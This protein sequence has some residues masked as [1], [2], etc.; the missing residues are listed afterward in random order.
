MG[1]F[2]LFECGDL[3]GLGGIGTKL[4]G[5]CQYGLK[6]IDEWSQALA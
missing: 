6:K 4:G 5:K 3:G 2:D 1:A